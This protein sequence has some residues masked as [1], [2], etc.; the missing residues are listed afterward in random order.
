MEESSQVELVNKG[1]VKM[2]LK[3][4][5]LPCPFCGSEAEIIN[6][7][8]RK[9][10]VTTDCYGVACPNKDCKVHPKIEHVRWHS[11]EDL[12]SELNE[13]IKIWNTRKGEAHEQHG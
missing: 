8:D 4:L 2:K 10:Y 3:E 13:I 9:S 12:S 7:T 11:D 5:P 1:G 6:I